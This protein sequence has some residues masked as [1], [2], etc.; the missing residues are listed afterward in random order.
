MHEKHSVSP[1]GETKNAFAGTAIL[2]G[3]IILAAKILGLIRDMLVARLY[4]TSLEAIAYET[5]SRLPVTVFDLVIGGVVTTAFIPV[6]NSLLVKE[7]EKAAKDFARS[8]VNLILVIT[9]SAALLG[10]VFASPLVSFM[11][12]ALEPAAHDLAVRLTRILFP[13]I[14]FTGLA[15]S[16]VG[17]LQS[18]GEYNI[19]ALISLLSNGIMVGYLLT[20]NRFFGILGLAVAMLLGWAAQALVQIPALRRLGFRYSLRTPLWTGP[21][22]R[23]MKNTLPILFSTWTTPVCTLINTRLASGIEGGRGITALGYA[24]R[25][26]T[27]LVGLFSFVAT[28]LLFPYFSRAA[29]VGEKEETDRLMRI[30]AKTLVYIIAPITVGIF[31]L[32]E[33]F[34]ALLYEDGSFTPADT[35]L[36]AEAL[37]CLALSMV[38]L[39]VNEVLVKGFFAAEETKVPMVS[40]LISMGA[41][42]GVLFLLSTLWSD[43]V[44][45]GWVALL[46]GGA[47]LLN[48]AIN[49]VRAHRRGM[50]RL[51]PGDW[52][53]L[54][55]TLLASLLMAPA[56]LFVTG[57]LDSDFLRVAAG[58]L[59]GMAVY[60]PLTLLLRSE[61]IT[62]LVG[63]LLRR[64]K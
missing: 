31:L 33:P 19:P 38:F 43:R 40:A 1:S 52:L 4:G 49:G 15:F 3:I 41:N 35:A 61:C 48:M 7:G 62:G 54:G 2:M 45:V 13:M 8:Y 64:R 20:L 44:T 9:L 50:M 56:V 25:L 14:V 36:T 47:T 24:N 16:F 46:S 51:G 53:D 42:V 26:Y 55:K 39:A 58:A 27:I 6:Y 63:G 34:T 30:S 17:Y 10:T 57:R 29:A 32:A 21:I 28:N 37:R 5:A 11:A 59:T 22:R 60:F 23:A 18:M 12:P